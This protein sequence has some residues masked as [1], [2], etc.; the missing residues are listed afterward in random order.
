MRSEEHT[1]E[2]QSPDQH[3]F[4]TRRSS[5]LNPKEFTMMIA[6]ALLVTIDSSVDGSIL[7]VNG[8]ISVKT[9]IA[10]SARMA[11]VTAIKLNEGRITSSPSPTFKARNEIGRAHV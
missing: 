8:S 5:D 11:F 7:H 9:G 2:L 1:S 10:F 3:S 6:F 4:P